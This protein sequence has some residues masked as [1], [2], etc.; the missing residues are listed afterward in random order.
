M[1]ERF[2]ALLCIVLGGV[3]IG[4][5]LNSGAAGG[6]G[7]AVTNCGGQIGAVSP[8]PVGT[9]SITKVTHNAPPSVPATWTVVITSTCI[10]PATGN[11]VHQSVTVPNNGTASST[12]LYIWP[13]STHATPC[14]YALVEDPLPAGDTASFDPA[15]PVTIP[16]QG[17]DS[18]SSISVTLTNTFA[19]PTTPPPSTAKPTTSAPRSTSAAP[20]SVAVSSSA[21]PIANTGPHEQVRASVWIGAT[22]CVLGLGLL[23][24]GRTR[25]RRG[26]HSD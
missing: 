3:L 17:S 12:N 21:E 13:D 6:V 26:A 8:C 14:S 16:Y 25:R 2:G 1:K 18:G 24:M 10:D 15:S 19:V 20:S 9:I 5:G 4:T 22:L 7:V 11:P 23:V